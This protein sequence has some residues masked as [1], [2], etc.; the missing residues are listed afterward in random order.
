MTEVF[1]TAGKTEGLEVWRVENLR[2]V[3]NEDAKLGNYYSGD[4]YVLLNTKL[5]KLKCLSSQINYIAHSLCKI[6]YHWTT[7]YIVAG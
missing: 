7:M 5:G 2:L 6:L 3:K 1:E 4:S